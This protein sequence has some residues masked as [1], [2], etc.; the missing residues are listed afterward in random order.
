MCCI[1]S[2]GQMV[3][4]IQTNS[5]EGHF[6]CLS[7]YFEAFIQSYLYQINTIYSISNKICSG[8]FDACCTCLCCWCGCC[9]CFEVLIGF[10]TVIVLSVWQVL[11]LLQDLCYWSSKTV[12]IATVDHHS[13]VS[14]KVQMSRY[15]IISPFL[16]NPIHSLCLV[17]VTILAVPL[18]RSC[19]CL[20]LLLILYHT[21]V[22]NSDSIA[23]HA[24]A[25]LSFI[26]IGKF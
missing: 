3:R 20:R 21:D 18:P 10:C 22:V 9:N 24:L 1:W 12:G 16:N 15:L 19:F 13:C 4:S 2:W 26:L 11:I 5:C 6:T 25:I 14:S 8:C 23:S 17:P 7:N